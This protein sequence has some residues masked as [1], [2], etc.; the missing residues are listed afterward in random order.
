MPD[1]EAIRAELNQT[2][3]NYRALLLSLSEQDWDRKPPKQ[4]WNVRQLAY[5]TAIGMTFMTNALNRLRQGKGTSPPGLLMG[6]L[7]VAAMLMIRRRSRGANKES[8]LALYDEGHA[9][10]LA[11]LDAMQESEW[12]QQAKVFA[13]L[14]TPAESFHHMTEHFEEHEAEIRSALI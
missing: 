8:L 6:P 7:N 1:T 5:H 10:A 11:A 2:R 4:S 13:E 3:E 12:S 14:T 9:K